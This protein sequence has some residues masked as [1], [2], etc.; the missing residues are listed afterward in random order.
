MKIDWNLNFLTNLFKRDPP[1]ES[2]IAALNL[3]GG[4]FS[5]WTGNA[6][7][8]DIYRSG[9][10]A[11]AR[12]AAKLKGVHTIIY[13]GERQPS[14]DRR[15]QKLLQ[16]SPNEYMTSYDMLY[17]L[18]TQY[19]LNNNAFALLDFDERGKLLGVYPI[20]YVH[21]DFQIDNLGKLYV[22]FTFRN[23]R[24]A[25][26][27]YSEVIH[28]RRHFN[29]NEFLGEDN[30]AL[31]TALEMAHTQ[32]E[33]ILQGIKN[34]GSLRGLLKL[35]QITKAADAK[36]I[37]QDFIKD[38]LSISNNG[39]VAV[40]DQTAEY[41]PLNQPPMTLDNGQIQATKDKIYAYL[42]IN[43]KIVNSSYNEDEFSAFYESVV[44]PLACQLSLE[45]TRKIFNDREQAFGNQIVFESGRL[46]FSSNKTKIELIK[47]LVP[48]GLLSINQALEVLN[49]API[50][51]GDRRLQTLN[52]VAFDKATEY[53][54]LKAGVA[55]GKSNTNTNTNSNTDATS[56][57]D[58]KPDEA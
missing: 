37:R 49:I 40:L 52:V 32:N 55:N 53:Q 13:G 17:K 41:I 57:N 31:D 3:N 46:Q 27:P 45:F 6:Y 7:A 47:E 23:G 9:V 25:Q 24:K 19:Y 58:G 35:T 12:N 48:L 54:L 20:N 34:S 1:K 14:N 36:Q 15:L 22:E 29:G 21:V 38:Y 30:R 42:G 28:L 10:D 16:V 56:G 4:G 51:G 8:N 43:E 5:T 50:E 11:I 33:G 44:E 26:F 2:R 39:G 18:V